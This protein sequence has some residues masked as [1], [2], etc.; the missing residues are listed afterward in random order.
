MLV[1]VGILHC[2]STVVLG[3][4]ELV[5]EKGHAWVWS[6]YV[7]RLLL[8][9][10]LTHPFTPLGSSVVVLKGTVGTV[11]APAWWGLHPKT[12]DGG[13]GGPGTAYPVPS[14]QNTDPFLLLP[15]SRWFILT[16]VIGKGKGI[17]S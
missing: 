16:G 7:G 14:P 2:A 12:D 10:P 1:Q 17:M 8:L 3:S 13:G 4:P 15:P 9:P 11:Q 5:F 6:L